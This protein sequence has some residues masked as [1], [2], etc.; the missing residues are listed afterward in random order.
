MIKGSD[1]NINKESINSDSNSHAES[2]LK[3]HHLLPIF[4]D[5]FNTLVSEKIRTPEVFMI[6]YLSSFLSKEELI[7]NGIHVPNTESKV[8]PLVKFPEDTKNPLIKKYLTKQLWN[9]IKYNVTKFRGNINDVLE[10]EIAGVTLTDGD[11]SIYI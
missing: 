7:K 8:V 10:D 2:Y 11:V 5:M 6:K 1:E 4:S 3:D 9:S